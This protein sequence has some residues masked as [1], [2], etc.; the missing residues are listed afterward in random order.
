MTDESIARTVERYYT[1]KVKTHGATPE[2]VDW[3][4]AEG[5]QLRFER[6]LEVIGDQD[7]PVSLNDFGCGYGALLEPAR[8]RLGRLRYR[9]YDLSPVMIEHARELHGEDDE[10]HFTSDEDELEVADFTI[11][12]GIFNVRLEVPPEDWRR[13]VLATIDKLAAISARGFSF[14]ALTSHSDSKHMREDL[15]YADPA[16]LLDYCLR[17]HSRD[18]ALHHDYGLYE[19][20][21]AV[22]TDGRGPAAGEEVQDDG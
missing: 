21:V 3:N 7:P 2:G 19:F 20:T 9:G 5:Q 22:R 18:V 8:R 13:H 17:R 15:Y 10:V 4:S 11:S 14:N 6:L 12:S 1:A 16:E